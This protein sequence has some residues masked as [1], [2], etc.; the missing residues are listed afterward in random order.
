MTERPGKNTAARPFEI[1]SG[2]QPAW[3]GSEQQTVPH[4]FSMNAIQYWR[5][6]AGPFTENHWP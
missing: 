3:G 2:F 5:R 6:R 4:R 1:P